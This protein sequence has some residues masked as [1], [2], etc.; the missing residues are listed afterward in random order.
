MWAQLKAVFK[1]GIFFF[2]LLL[3]GFALGLLP[4]RKPVWTR[5]GKSPPS[6]SCDYLPLSNDT[7]STS[8]WAT[9]HYNNV[10]ASSS[11]L[12]AT[13]TPFPGEAHSISPSSLPRTLASSESTTTPT[14][15]HPR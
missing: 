4:R 1:I 6:T 3:L 7:Q 10:P 9:C 15:G 11:L 12:L 13:A 14:A 5:P 8:G 2:Y